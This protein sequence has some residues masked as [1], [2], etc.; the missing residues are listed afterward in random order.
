MK[1]VQINEYG[2]T[3]V[4]NIVEIAK[5][6]IS[7][8]QILVEVYASSLNPFDSVIRAGN[9]KETIPLQLPVTLGGDVSGIVAEVGT[10][11]AG[12][13]I[14]DKIYG[15]ANVVAGNSGAFAEFAATSAGQVAKIPEGLDFKQ[16]ASLPLVG[17]SAWQGIV[18]HINLKSGQKIFIHG[19]AGGIGTVAIQIAKHIGAYVATS[20]TADGLE[21]VKQL[22]ADEVIDYKSQEFTE[23]LR[24]YDAVF[25][26]AGGGEFDKTLNI[27]KRGGVAVS[28][29]AHA[30]EAKV[31]ELGVVAITQATKVT[32]E[33]LDA[34]SELV[35]AGVISPHVDKVFS[36]DQIREAFEARESG[37]V[38][39]KIVIE[40]KV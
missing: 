38:L 33:A 30:N 18:Q 16:A 40:V 35:S 9:M 29:I 37:A 3:S 1:A 4:L 32:A 10:S 6:T 39:G 15:Q 8:N 25:E 17:V 23:V 2:D 19:G 11:V 27:L 5:P 14:G 24:D 13:R 31:E 20:A 12:I 36:L 7:E 21:Y 22:G 34:L 26:L 28:M